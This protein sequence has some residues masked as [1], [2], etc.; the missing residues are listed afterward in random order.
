MKINYF[1]HELDIPDWVNYVVCD[2]YNNILGYDCMPCIV[3]DN[4]VNE[5]GSKAYHCFTFP[6][7]IDWQ[8]S[9]VRVEGEYIEPEPEKLTMRD[10]FA[11]SALNGI[12]SCP[13]VTAGKDE[14]VKYAYIYADLMIEARKRK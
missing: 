13:D 1:S 11:M 12:I 5:H 8:D 10:H 2:K 3:N 6:Y 9:L 14:I 4:W 7:D